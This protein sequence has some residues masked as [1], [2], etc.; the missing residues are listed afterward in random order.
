[1]KIAIY[2]FYQAFRLLRNSKVIMM[3]SLLPILL[4]AIFYGL[5][6]YLLFSEA[7]PWIKEIIRS[8]LDAPDIGLPISYLLTILL[9]VFFYLM[10]NWTFLIFVSLI[11][12]PFNDYI[13]RKINSIMIPNKLMDDKITFAKIKA[14][15]INEL[16][17]MS[18][19]LI[20]SIS[21]MVIGFIPI[22]TP[23]SFILAAI[24][25]SSSFLDY[26]WSN[27][28]LS[29]RQCVRFIASN[30]WLIILTGVIFIFFMSIPLL[31]LVVFP[32]AVIYYSVLFIKIEEDEKS[33]N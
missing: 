13:C 2:T 8:F 17:K 7:L 30:L 24:L 10:M 28:D 32:F 27:K 20:I 25:L 21:S 15:V 5:G 1:M 16:K 4:G 22:L 33:I 19:I 23:L 11:S 9:S 6:G 31:N 3:L 26:S 29:F 14:I 18:L 12:C